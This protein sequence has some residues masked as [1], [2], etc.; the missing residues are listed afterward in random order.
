MA[1]ESGLM[2]L[3]ARRSLDGMA[4]LGSLAPWE[5]LGFEFESG[6]LRVCHMQSHRPLMGKLT[7]HGPCSFSIDDFRIT[8]RIQKVC[9]GVLLTSLK[10]QQLVAP[11]G[12]GSVSG[13]NGAVWHVAGWKLSEIS[14]AQ[15]KSCAEP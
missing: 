13:G 6:K 11:F 14:F 10:R 2:T 3:P 15:K 7:I 5:C 9:H 4:Y 1:P 12:C 8:R